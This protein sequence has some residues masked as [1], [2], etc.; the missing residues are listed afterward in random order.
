MAVRP[1]ARV[2]IVVWR[3]AILVAGIAGWWILALVAGKNFVPTPPQTLAAAAT[4]LADGTL[5]RASRDTV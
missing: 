5:L 3:L 4:M 1:F 2:N